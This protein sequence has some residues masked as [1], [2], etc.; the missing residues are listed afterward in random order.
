MKRI[1]SILLCAVILSAL[2]VL[3]LT[4][5]AAV[6]LTGHKIV[7]ILEVIDGKYT[8]MS[9]SYIGE[10]YIVDELP[11]THIDEEALY[12]LTTNFMIYSYIN[13]EWYDI[14]PITDWYEYDGWIPDNLDDGWYLLLELPPLMCDGSACNVADHDNN[15]ICDDCGLPFVWS[16]RNDTYDFNGSYFP[17]TVELSDGSTSTV[18]EVWDIV[19]TTNGNVLIL[20]SGDFDGAILYSF[21]QPLKVSG[22]NVVNGKNAVGNIVTLYKASYTE[23]GTPY[24]KYNGS[25]VWKNEG[26]LVASTSSVLWSADNINDQ[27]GFAVVN[28]DLNFMTPLWEKVEQVTQGMI[29]TLTTNLG[30]TFQ[31][32]LICSVGLMALL[33]GCWILLRVLRTYLR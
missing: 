4:A 31:T 23:D 21:S 24:W 22:N 8:Y 33:V 9:N 7:D 1:F 3:P 18:R 6:D 19:K 2:I 10:Y 11:S 29:P 25:S 17:T 32:L 30:G 13:N 27:Y 12:F 14:V 15:N 28:G 26:S 20:S 5:S 16:L